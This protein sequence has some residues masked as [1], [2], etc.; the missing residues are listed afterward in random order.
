MHAFAQAVAAQ[1]G[2]FERRHLL[3]LLVVS[4][5]WAARGVLEVAALVERGLCRLAGGQ[6]FVAPCWRLG[7]VCA[8]TAAIVLSLLSTTLRPLHP[9]RAAH[10]Q[11]ADWLLAQRDRGT[12]LDTV[13]HGA[14]YT[15]RITY[16]HEIAPA[17]LADPELRYLV[18]ESAEL[19]YA[20]RRAATLRELIERFAT[21][22]AAFTPAAG[23]GG[24]EVR[25]YRWSHQRFAL[26]QGWNHAR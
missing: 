16:R 14:L 21:P 2:Y 15:H 18:V 5:P 10:R 17:A 11:A 22:A 26:H 1:R 20:S 19:S 8:T 24:P 9:G 13:G 3:P 23:R 4:L 6:W 12:V 25:V 7:L